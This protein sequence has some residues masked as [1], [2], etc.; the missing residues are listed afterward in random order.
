MKRRDEY[1]NLARE[2]KKLWNM[3][4]TVIPIVVSTLG[5]ILKEF[6]KGQENLEIRRPAET[7]ALLSSARILRRVLDTWRDLLLL[8][9]QRKTINLHW[10]EKFSNNNNNNSK[11]TFYKFLVQSFPSPRLVAIWK[12][13][14]QSSLLLEYSWRESSWIYTCKM[15]HPLPF[16][17]MI[18]TNEKYNVEK[19]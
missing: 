8:K 11:I 12:L 18:T 7:I 13:K 5:T 17:S 19:N 4:V 10:C 9:L 15:K 16:S 3:K 6:L 2:L 14:S 1:L